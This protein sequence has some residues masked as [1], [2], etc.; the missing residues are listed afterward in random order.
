MGERLVFKV[1]YEGKRLCDIYYHW[2]AWPIDIWREA[3]TLYEGLKKRSWSKGNTSAETLLL[4]IDTLINDSLDAAIDWDKFNKGNY[5]YETAPRFNAHG[6]L[7]PKPSNVEAAKRYFAENGIEVKL[8]EELTG[9]YA[10]LS[11]NCG[12]LAVTDELMKEYEDWAEDLC[13]LDLDDLTVTN[14]YLFPYEDEPDYMKELIADGKD[15]TVHDIAIPEDLSESHDL[16]I[17]ELDKLNDAIEWFNN[18]AS[19]YSFCKDQY[20]FYYEFKC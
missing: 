20:G 2:S 14:P 8:D 13:E 3:R 5:T 7:Q 10:T 6:G 16:S 18:E 17:L 4:I 19:G 12:I 9:E 15:F 1:Q 11:R